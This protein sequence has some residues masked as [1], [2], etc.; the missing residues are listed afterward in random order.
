[1]Q[2]LKRSNDR[3]FSRSFVGLVLSVALVLGLVSCGSPSQNYVSYK[4]DGVYLAVPKTWSE[5]SPESL[6]AQ[7]AKSTAAG[8]TE[9]AAA[10][11]WQIAY[12]TD[13][14]VTASDVFSIQNS[15]NPIVFLRIRSLSA[16]ERNLV[17]LNSLRDVIVPLSSWIDGALKIPV[18]TLL[19]DGELTEKGAS[20]IHSRFI[21]GPAEGEPQ[22]LDQSV[23]LSPDRNTLYVLV[24]RC[25]KTCFEQNQEV[26]DKIV[27]SLRVQ[28]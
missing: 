2:S 21:F 23:L 12:S 14:S 28:G 11:K 16:V 17:S 18:F 15:N 1:M 4:E 3:K 26:L 10:V 9:R 6:A 7:E 13:K 24:A 19:E 27:A 5:I 25:S 22:T 20:G 8:A